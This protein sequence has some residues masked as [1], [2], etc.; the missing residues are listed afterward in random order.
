MHIVIVGQRNGKAVVQWS[1]F[2]GLALVLSMVLG[3]GTGLVFFLLAGRWSHTPVLSG[4]LI[5][6]G[7][8]LGG[9]IT[10]LRTP[11]ERL[12]PLD[13]QSTEESD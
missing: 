1:R 12:S 6:A 5:G 8:A 10:G 11:P 13:P 7:I 9:L 2:L 4:L 3:L